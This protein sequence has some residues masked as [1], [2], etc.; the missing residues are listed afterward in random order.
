MKNKLL[1]TT[2]LTVGLLSVSEGVM[3]QPT[4]DTST[5]TS[6]TTTATTTSSSSSSS[7]IPYEFGNLHV[8][9]DALMGQTVNFHEIT[10]DTIKLD[11]VAS[12]S[13]AT[14]FPTTV[15]ELDKALYERDTNIAKIQADPNLTEDEKAKLIAAEEA[16]Y[17]EI[18]KKEEDRIA[19]EKAVAD[20]AQRQKDLE[21]NKAQQDDINAQ[22]DAER[23]AILDDPNLTDE[24]RDLL[25]EENELKRQEAL[26]PLQEQEKELSKTTEQREQEKAIAEN[27]AAQDE[28]NQRYNEQ[29]DSILNDQSLSEEERNFMLEELEASRMG[30]LEGLEQERASLEKT[31]TE[32]AEE[33]AAQRK[34]EI[35]NNPDMSEEEKAMAKAQIDTELAETKAEI[36][37]AQKQEL[38]IQKEAANQL[39]QEKQ[40]AAEQALEQKKQEWAKEKQDLQAQADA[41]KAQFEQTKKTIE[42]SAL[43]QEEKDKMLAQKES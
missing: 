12:P 13:T 20:E 34:E 3:A 40:K 9:D 42:E 43:S 2:I 18:V 8:Y 25:L 36:E 39:V 6:T 37:A 32:R 22:Y 19:H 29:M 38:E 31:A 14:S 15:S 10:Q 28:V 5:T 4:T 16:K 17:Q 33:A 41:A 7:Y 11:G 27:Q 35:D 30:E 1:L 21:A 24:E 23:M 26:A